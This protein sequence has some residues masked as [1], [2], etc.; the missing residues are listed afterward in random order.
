MAAKSQATRQSAFD[1]QQSTIDNQLLTIENQ[2]SA[3]SNQQSTI[4][5]HNKRQQKADQ[6][7]EVACRQAP[8]KSHIQQDIQGR[9]QSKSMAH[10]S[11]RR[12]QIAFLHRK[13][14]LLTA[15]TWCITWEVFLHSQRHSESNKKQESWCIC[16][17]ILQVRKVLGFLEIHSSGI[18]YEGKSQPNFDTCV[19]GF[20]YLRRAD[21]KNHH[22]NHMKLPFI[23]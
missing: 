18:G 17:V 16:C 6:T 9:K 5:D 3:I 15:L 21:S 19:M 7:K 13:V 14:H 12:S 2:Q 1:N 4:K 10:P 23:L 22:K 8:S 20:I 11:F